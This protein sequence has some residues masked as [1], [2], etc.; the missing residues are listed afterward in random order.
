MGSGGVGSTQ[1]IAVAHMIRAC[2]EQS[3]ELRKTPFDVV[4]R[5]VRPSERQQNALD[6]IRSAYGQAIII[7]KSTV[8]RYRSAAQARGAL[9]LQI[10]ADRRD[11]LGSRQGFA[12]CPG[13]SSPAIDCTR[14]GASHVAIALSP[15]KRAAFYN[16]TLLIVGLLVKIQWER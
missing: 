6:T 5:T 16:S 7:V 9:M 10:P 15:R 1:H 4:S 14:L 8:A 3:I 11:R 13:R 12:E 2:E